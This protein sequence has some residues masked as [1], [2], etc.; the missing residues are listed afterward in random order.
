MTSRG[1]SQTRNAH[2]RS[3]LGTAAALALV[4]AP[5][6][7]CSEAAVE[8]AEITAA[9][10]QNP[11]TGEP[12]IDESVIDESVIDELVIEDVE[13]TEVPDPLTFE[14]Q[15][16]THDYTADIDG[17]EVIVQTT[18]ISYPYFEGDSPATANINALVAAYVAARI[19]ESDAQ[20]LEAADVA[21]EILID[22]NR[23]EAFYSYTLTSDVTLNNNGYL[24]IRF[25][26]ELYTAGAH[27]NVTADTSLVFNTTT[28]GQ[29]Q[30]NDIFTSPSAVADAA[31]SAFTDAIAANPTDFFD[32]A[33]DTLNTTDFAASQEENGFGYYLT[34][35]GVTF[36]FLPYFLAPH[37]AGTQEALVPFTSDLVNL[38]ALVN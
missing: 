29:L 18:N 9:T 20:A 8:E 19:L 2:L 35:N 12:V 25:I 34:D 28:G 30:F 24:G 36:L 26:T 33:L 21:T 11:A 7:G 10:V 5:L 23:P 37:A 4:L 17:A 31:T 38:T 22:Q 6:A 1:H 3:W 14:M 27:P 13:Q 32:E 16:I 15:E